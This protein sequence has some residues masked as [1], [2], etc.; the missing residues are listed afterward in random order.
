MTEIYGAVRISGVLVKFLQHYITPVGTMVI[1]LLE[2][3]LILSY[4]TSTLPFHH[5]AFNL[6]RGGIYASVGWLALSSAVVST[7]RSNSESIAAGEGGDVAMQWALLSITPVFFSTGAFLVHLKR[8]WLLDN[9][10]RFRVECSLEQAASTPG[11]P[12]PLPVTLASRRASL[13]SVPLRTG[14]LASLGTLGRMGSHNSLPHT[15]ARRRD[16]YLEFFDSASR[17]KRAFD[18]AMSALA[19]IRTLLYERD[20][21]D[22]PLMPYLFQRA[23]EENPESQ[24]LQF[25]YLIFLRFVLRDQ[26]SAAWRERMAK[27]ADTDLMIDLKYT[28]Y[29]VGRKAFQQDAGTSMGQDSISAIN[30]MEFSAKMSAVRK[31]HVECIA[32]VKTIWKLASKAKREEHSIVLAK[33]LIFAFSAAAEAMAQ[34]AQKYQELLE[35]FPGSASLRLDYASFCDVVLNDDVRA[36]SLR[37]AAEGLETGDEGG[38]GPAVELEEVKSRT[39][40]SNSSSN[41]SHRT[42]QRLFVASWL[43]QVMAPQVRAL[44]Q[45]RLLVRFLGLVLLTFSVCGFLVM[46]VY[47]IE[48]VVAGRLKLLDRTR[49]YRQNTY[50]CLLATR[51]LYLLPNETASAAASASATTLRRSVPPPPPLSRPVPRPRPR[52]PPCAGQCLCLCICCPSFSLAVLLSILLTDSLV[53][54]HLCGAACSRPTRQ[55]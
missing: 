5:H 18:S 38:S 27:I 47:L 8:G 29:A 14:S 46:E 6:L 4:H 11:A 54:V 1:I 48:T 2:A 42:S 26:Q 9:I 28:L 3:V 44:A 53:T 20:E 43:D 30:L 19:S 16:M 33:E 25:L 17:N 23:M 49:G 10:R 32:T 13:A 24:D 45:L 35:K 31:K 55:R 36:D 51:N 39:S 34:T 21:R 50:K 7:S 41:I 12:N 15:R 40:K 22:V 52:P 37:H